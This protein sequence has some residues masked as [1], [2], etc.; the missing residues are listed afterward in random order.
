VRWLRAL[1][2][3]GL[4]LAALTAA[5]QERILE[6]AADIDIDASTQ[7]TV[8]ERIT[9]QVAGQRF[10]HG[11]LRDFPTRYQDRSGSAVTVPFDVVGV[12]RDGEAEPW[13]LERLANGVRVRI[14]A[15]G[16][17]LAPGVHRYEITYRTGRQLGFFATH[18]ELYWNVTGNG[19]PFAID[20][21]SAHVR[22]PKPVPAAQLMADAYTGPF[23]ATGRDYRASV[24]DG[25]FDFASTRRLAPYEGLTIV[26]AFPKGIL[27]APSFARRV[28]WWLGDN[29]GG[30]VGIAGTLIA[31]GFLGFCWYRIGRDPPAGPRFPRYDAPTGLSAAAVRFIDRM[32]FDSRCFAAGLLGLGSR[33]YLTIRAD[34]N[35]YTV[36]ATGQEVPLLGGDKAMIGP[37]LDGKTETV[38][39]KTYDPAVAS[40]QRALAQA[41]ERRYDGTLFRRNRG[42]VVL[43]GLAGSG[44]IAVGAAMGAA[45]LVCIA[46]SIVLLAALIVFWRLMPAYTPD[47]RKLRDHIEGLREYL[48]VA[49]R[50]DLARMK[51]PEA[52]PAEFA[53]MLPFALALGVEKTWADRFAA[54]LGAAAVS[55]AVAH[56]YQQNPASGSTGPGSVAGLTRSLDALGGTVAAAS[57]APG[58]SSGSS[59]DGGGGGSSGGGGGGGGGDGW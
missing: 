8:T 42:A 52:T 15:A 56:Y 1:V 19:W 29:R 9:V 51:T 26:A 24:E 30:A 35:A 3:L 23:G 55:A 59:S 11:L 18:D 27:P 17:L 31:L 5:A 16:V 33:G 36:Q 48:S 47:G 20:N 7:L 12:Q 53:R 28:L 43:G 21:A 13:R 14:G 37:L 41:L 25:A 49:E 50:T 46:L 45:P 57:T 58:S 2:A 22:L 34:A 38:V 54:V 10:Q 32:R 39:S 40:S 6:F 4:S 44:A